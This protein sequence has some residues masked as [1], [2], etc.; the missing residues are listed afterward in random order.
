MEEEQFVSFESKLFLRRRE[1][2]THFSEKKSNSF[3]H[4][5]TIN[6]ML[7]DSGKETFH[8]DLVNG[9]KCLLN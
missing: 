9:N 3:I 6:V 5:S 2:V 7:E 1:S 8:D 4:Q